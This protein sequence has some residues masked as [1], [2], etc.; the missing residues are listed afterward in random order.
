MST[1]SPS[2]AAMATSSS[3]PEV[4]S[5]DALFAPGV[6]AV[7]GGGASANAKTTSDGSSSSYSS[8]FAPASYSSA[9][10]SLY[11]PSRLDSAAESEARRLLTVPSVDEG[12]SFG[13][14]SMPQSGRAGSR[15]SGS[16]R[17]GGGDSASG[18]TS[19]RSYHARSMSRNRTG[20]G[21]GRDV[22][23]HR[24]EPGS[25]RSRA[26]SR[27][28]S[29][30]SRLAARHGRR[31]E[32]ADESESDLR[33]K[34]L[35]MFEW[36]AGG[37]TVCLLGSWD[38]FAVAV[39]M[40]TVRPGCFRAVVSVPLGRLTY[41]F[42]VD[43]QPK[44]NPDCPTL[45]NEAGV[46]VNVRHGGSDG[47][48]DGEADEEWGKGRPSRARRVLSQV[49]G[50]DLYSQHSTSDIVSMLVFRFFYLAMIPA[51][52]YYFFW[53]SVRGGNRQAPVCWVVFVMSEIL[54]FV[55]A[56]ISLFGMW[57]PIKRRWRS[58]DALRP[59]LPV[60][61]WPT[62][63][64]I[65]CHYKE[66]T[67]QLRQTIR[68]AMKLDYP[69]HLLH[70]LIADDGFFP[71][72]KMVERSDI[73][74]ALYQTCVEE[75]G[76]DPLL[77]ETMN[78]R[79]L[80]EHYTVKAGDDLPRHDCA[81]EA[82][83]FE[84][85]PYGADMYG[86]GALPRLS[87]V[88]R[89]KPADAHNKAGNINNVLSN[90]NAE[91]KIVLFLDADMKPVESYLLRVLP[92]MLE[93]QRSDSLQSQLI[94][95]EDPELGAGT[96]KSWQ[97]N[98]DI[99]FVGC[100]QRFANVS[101]DHPDY[102]AHRNAIY[103]DGICTGRDGF[104]MTDFVGT[105]AC[106]RREVLNEIGGFV[107]GSV[108]E[109]TLTSNEVHR[110][111]YISRYAD[112]DLCW[113]EAP[114]TVAAALLQRQRWAKGAIMNGMRI[115]KGAAKERKEMLL[116]REKPSELSEFYAYRRQQRKPNNTFVSTMFWL[117]ST[118]YPLLGWGA[119]GY[120]FCAI[121]YLITAQAPIS[122][123]STQSLAGAFVTYYLIRYGAFFSAF[124]E[125]NMTD[126]LRSQQCWF[127]YSFAHT[128]GVW[129]ALFGGAK[130]GWVANTGQ[131]HRR[132]WL[133]WFNILT[134]G[135]LLSGI[136]WR[137][138]AFIVIEEACSPYENFGA[139]AFGGYVAWMMAPVALVSL[140]ERL[141]S[142]DESEREGKPMPVPTPIIAAALTI[143]GVVFL[144]GWANA[145]C[146]IEARG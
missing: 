27:D 80:V 15:G 4:H 141:S 109:D 16:G 38:R 73:G 24:G 59:A 63:D 51:G 105:N 79:G 69:A 67:E 126:V 108:T 44:Y 94:Q 86:P 53:L 1:P 135:A 26:A 129:D 18:T 132:S 7:P 144:S 88:A 14:S 48:C 45:V 143:L 82:H 139:V 70:I 96:S 41:S 64:V 34:E 61:D 66:D 115:F 11:P 55:S 12:A 98:R 23:G 62:V 125:V 72:S 5:M 8:G 99:G 101:G 25:I 130:F 52:A 32:P 54:S 47:D 56:L 28:A 84:F 142:A 57:K 43:G 58:L 137:L 37:R 121:F 116:S 75:A 95:A 89:V 85:G 42:L 74:L 114:V 128:V 87:L 35:H 117:D 111:G 136:V 76:Y 91:G 110:R 122:P 127:S 131:R 78:E 124:Y 77:E 2:L 31:L 30:A 36:S 46:R 93:E 118:L 65:I 33:T 3:S 81:V 140:N 29:T 50:L 39:P 102:C 146:G 145:R 60:A 13:V 71:T 113:G 103:Y 107:Y 10:L 97:I 49:S 6:A 100:P 9:T 22:G 90:S 138:F 20:G 133:E 17:H 112:E 68:A 134:L 104:G 19:L 92:L 21:G 40:E 119:F 123:T 106:W 120:V 83:Q